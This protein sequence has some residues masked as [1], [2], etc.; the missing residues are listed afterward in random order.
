MY[1]YTFPEFCTILYTH[2]YVCMY[3]CMYTCRYIFQSLARVLHWES[4]EETNFQVYD[5]GVSVGLPGNVNR[6]LTGG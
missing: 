6:F 1:V 3:V 5:H 2:I 4:W